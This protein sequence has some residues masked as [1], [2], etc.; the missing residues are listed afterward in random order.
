MTDRELRR[1]SRSELLEIL[2]ALSKENEELQERLAEMQARLDDKAIAIEQCGSVAEAALRLNGVFEAAQKACEQYIA[3]M[4]ARA[5]LPI[6][7]DPEPVQ[8]QKTEPLQVLETAHEQ[9]A[10]SDPEPVRLE[11]EQETESEAASDGEAAE[12]EPEAEPERAA[13]PIVTEAPGRRERVP[14]PKRR[15]KWRNG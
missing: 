5:D 11:Q 8:E 7:A 9:E 12:P 6:D 4:K 3:N 15:K 14:K 2:I 13:E 1:L 10:E